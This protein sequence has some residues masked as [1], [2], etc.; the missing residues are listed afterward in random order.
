M[1]ADSLP[2]GPPAQCTYTPV[3]TIVIVLFVVSPTLIY[4]VT[5]SLYHLPPIPPPS[6]LSTLLL[7][8]VLYECG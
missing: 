8:F 3:L 2:S 5:S 4:L 7:T 1:Q 6:T